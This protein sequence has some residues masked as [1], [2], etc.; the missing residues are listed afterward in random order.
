VSTPGTGA[1]A[2]FPPGFLWGAA[3]ASYQVEGFPLAD[4]AGA[5]IWHR[6]AHTPGNMAAGHTGDVACDHYH[7]WPEDV[8]WLARLG[9][10]AYRFSVSWSRILPDGTGRVNERGLD[11]YK[12]LVDA[13]R[14]RGITPLLTLYHWDLPAALD[15]RGGWTNPDSAQWFA[16]YADVMFRALGDRVPMWATLNEPWVIVDGG[17]LHGGLAPGHRGAF[18]AVRAA[19]NLLLAH[20]AAV[21]AFRAAAPPTAQIGIVI[22]LEPKD[23]ATD[24]PED[25]AATRRA[26]AQFNRHYMDALFLGHYP[27]EL[28][29]VYGEAWTSFPASDFDRIGRPLD[30]VGINYYSRGL[31]AFDA[32]AWPTYARKV[33]NPGAAYTALGWEVYPAGLTRALTWVRDRY[34]PL[35]L[36]VTENGMAVEEPEHLAPGATELDDPLRVAYFAAHLAAVRDAIAAGVDVRGYFAWSLLD[37]LEWAHGFTKRFGLLHVDF[38]A[39]TRTPKTSARFLREVARTNGACVGAAAPG[40]EELPELPAL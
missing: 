10:S 22:N 27:A 30:F 17:Y 37:N 29:Q 36:Y 12:R 19:H 11:F 4:G 8:E 23:A 26:D 1:G 3:T 13:V 32:E 6:F 25:V 16:D 2:A 35:P 39:L 20:G 40:A 7:R 38:D 28:A 5:S 15:D 14:A 33:E 31:T 9:L 18:G 24:A 34:T 21:D